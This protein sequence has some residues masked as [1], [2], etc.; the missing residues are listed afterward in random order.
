M[1]MTFTN[2]LRVDN[3]QTEPECIPY[4]H[5]SRRNQDIAVYYQEATRAVA[6]A[7][8]WATKPEIPTAA[9]ILAGPPGIEEPIL[10]IDE[11]LRPNKV[12]GPYESNEEYLGTQY[13]LLREDLIRPLRQAVRQVQ[14][15]PSKLE[16]D[17]TSGIGVYEPV[18]L[19][20][21][22]FSARGLSAKVAF[23][24][25]RVQKYIRWKQSK[26]LISGTLVALSPMAD[27]FNT[28]CILATVGARPLSGLEANN[29]PEIDLFIARPEDFDFDPMQKWIMVES[30]SSFFEAGRH[31]LLALQHMMREPFPL[32][33]HLVKVEKD[34]SAPASVDNDPYM[35]LSSLVS[36]N[37][38]EA[39][40][41]VNIFQSW[42]AGDRMTLDTSQSNA[43]NRMMTKSLAI[44]QGPPGTGKTHTSVVF[45]KTL[46]ANLSAGDPPII[47]TC[48]TNHALDQLLRHVAEFEP[49]FVRLGGQTK[50]QK[51]IKS[52][53]LYEVRDGY[54]Q[55]RI[56][57]S[58]VNRAYG[59]I[60]R[61][62]A[63]M[64]KLLA[65][66]ESK[67]NP[68]ALNHKLL[69]EL[70]LITEKQAMSLEID[71]EAAMGIRQDVPGI[72]MEQWLGK[73]LQICSR[74]F[75]EDDFGLAYEEEDFDEVEKVEELEAEVVARDD[76]DLDA[77]NGLFVSISDNFKGSTNGSLRTDDD[78]R[79]ILDV[80]DDL[81]T[82]PVP[83]RGA[84]YNYLLRQAKR[85]IFGKFR[86]LAK[87]YDNAVFQRKLGRW[88]QDQP[89]LQDQRL[90]GMTT[91]GLSK[92]RALISSLR[93]KV[94][95]IEE[96]AETL[97]PPVTAACFPT[98]EHLILVGDHQ[99]LRPHC[100][101]REFEDE[102]YNFNMSLFERLVLNEIP[103]DTLTR[104]RRM[105]P[106]IRRLL[107]PIYGDTLKD[108]PS[109]KST[110]NRPP[111]EGM[112]GVNSFFLTHNWPES[113]DN[114]QSAKNEKEA[115]MIVGFYDYLVLNGVNPNRITVLTFYNGQRKLITSKLQYHQNLR[116]QAHKVVTVD[117]YQGEE[118]DIVLLSLVRSN[119]VSSI[120][121][122]SIDNRVCVA[123]SRA[124]RGFYL[125][126]NAEL[127]VC[128]S[129][130]WEAVVKIFWGHG[131]GKKD[132]P[133]ADLVT[134]IG[135]YSTLA[136]V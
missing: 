12:D 69:A 126:G 35:D 105:V 92:Y 5:P 82:I 99:Q 132:L 42:P 115:Q 88:E 23:S 55:P 102:P 106:E 65:P 111:V 63:E 135:E 29:P 114:N 129:N 68:S 26:R 47:V 103:L 85:H 44:V 7:G 6:G 58:R 91:T 45:L 48:Q 100:N 76:D 101:L 10:D 89:I 31:T 18:Y 49:K 25:N 11:R 13:E 15:D 59:D 128:N 124:R 130:T 94:V 118:N 52:R 39:F 104:Q 16:A 87:K 67:D 75:R 110:E 50:D 27:A 86:Q 41:D 51:V 30:R 33:R 1:F 78:V 109:V 8:A 116:G 70:G 56:P 127:L 107:Q 74:P 134:R 60:K 81:T 80:T 2:G 121:F 19:K 93:P 131:K 108:H 17:Y 34:I 133:T 125:F 57:G 90:I 22:Q 72:Q 3:Q 83:D 120:G 36:L 136:T 40:R 38:S 53:T 28:Q 123:L 71:A 20:G 14:L 4:S 112:G 96:A 77:L 43:L 37:D 46:L 61:L 113:R 9:E 64:S 84:V 73:C 95:L 21:I 62:T 66:L 122:L 79:R 24:L 97:E 98:L 32:S 117:S 54:K 119:N